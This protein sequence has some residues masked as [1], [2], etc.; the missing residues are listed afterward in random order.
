MLAARITKARELNQKI[1]HKPELK[2]LSEIALKT[3]A[4]NYLLYKTLD[5]LDYKYKI[6]VYEIMSVDYDIGDI[7]PIIEYEPYWER[8]CKDKYKSETCA[9]NGNSWKQCYAENYVKNLITNYRVSEGEKTMEELR[10]VCDLVKY[11]IFNLDIPTFSCSFDISFIPQYFINL[12]S[13]NIKYSPILRDDKNP[14][15]EIFTKKLQPI[16][17][18]YSQF[19]IRIPDLKK[20]CILITDLSYFLS[21]TLTGNLVDDEMIKWLVPGLITNQTLRELDLSS[22]KITEKGMI[23]IASYLVRTR[24]LISIDL[25]DNLIGGESSFAI[26][27]V[28]KE[29]TKLRILKL[30]MNRFDDLNGSRIIKMIAKNNYLEELDMSTN[31]LGNETLKNLNLGLKFNSVIKKI[32]LSHNEITMNEETKQI[33]ESHPTLAVLDLRH[34]NSDEKLLKELQ[35]CLIKKSI[36][37]QLNNKK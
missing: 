24:S 37:L 14:N 3:V 22:N 15:E 34:T 2:D 30:A 16:G 35:D 32:D 28:L 25:S 13:L 23:K 1:V 36:K 18:E 31:L 33:A 19:G 9:Q 7:F 12:T 29:N 4:K 26:G 8:V 17:D 6:K 10:R 27:L 5:G 11:H 20:F 21:L